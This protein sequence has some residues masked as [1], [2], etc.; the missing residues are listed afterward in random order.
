M[1][2]AAA[3][4]AIAWGVSQSRPAGPRPTTSTR[5]PGPGRRWHHQARRTGPGDDDDGHVRDGRRVD[6]ARRLDELVSAAGRP[7]DVVRL[8][9]ASRLLERLPDAGVAAADLHDRGRP[10]AAQ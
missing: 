2:S 8:R 7:L 4:T 6:L 9:Q 5:P 3:R 10:G 1:S